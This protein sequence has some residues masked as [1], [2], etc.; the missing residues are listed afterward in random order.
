MT[1]GSKPKSGFLRYRWQGYSEALLIYLLG[2]G[3]PTHPL[4]AESYPQWTAT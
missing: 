1:L 3:S 4:P 2:L